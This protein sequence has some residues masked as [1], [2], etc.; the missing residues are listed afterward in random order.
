MHRNTFI[1]TPRLLRPTLQW[2]DR[3]DLFF[4]GQITGTE[5][6]VGSTA[7]GLLAGI[8]A[9]RVA[10]GAAA[11]HPAAHDHDG[12]AVPLH[13]PRRSAKVFQPMKANF[14]LLPELD[15]PVRDKRL[16]H[17]AYAAPWPI[18][19][20]RWRDETGRWRRR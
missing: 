1:N 13:H 8:N 14:G 20:R 3:D 19:T 2:R 15:P 17:A 6:Y 9:A 18:S 5:G 4:A 7:G 10:R 16:R 12:R 11:D